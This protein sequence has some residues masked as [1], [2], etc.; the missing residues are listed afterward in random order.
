VN[1]S[2]ADSSLVDLYSESDAEFFSKAHGGQSFTPDEY[3][4]KE[5]WRVRPEQVEVDLPLPNKG[6]GFS[7]IPWSTLDAEEWFSVKNWI[8]EREIKD[9]TPDWK[10][11]L[12]QK[13]HQELMGKILQ[14]RGTCSVY[15]GTSK[16]NVQFLSQIFEG[17]E[18]ITENNSVAWIFLLDG[19]LMRVSPRS[20]I[21]FHEIN[22]S[23]TEIFILSRLNEGHLFWHPRKKMSFIPDLGAE[24]DSLSLPLLVREANQQYFERKIFHSQNDLERVHEVINLED[25]AVETQ[26]K[27]LNEIKDDNDR[28]LTIPTKLMMVF[29]N[30]T[31]VAKEVSFDLV[32][33]LGGESYFKKR[34]SSS[35]DVFSLFLR[36][37]LATE[38]IKDL[39]HQWYLVSPTGRTYS[40]ME[41]VHGPLQVLELLTKRIKTIELARE[42]WVKEFSVP[43]LKLISLPEKMAQTYGHTVWGQELEKRYQFLVDYTRRIETTNLGSIEKLLTKLEGQEKKGPIQLSEDLYS[44]SLNHYL[45]GL[46][47]RYDSKK[48]R[49]KEMN[50]LQYYVWILKNGK[51]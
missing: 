39:D 35:S 16:A 44:T 1:R 40:K 45:L 47:S 12:R 46:K 42:I 33:L 11:G 6:Q 37:Y 4:Q 5:S 3:H 51:I 32:Y 27:T 38:E 36:G 8:I 24:T 34:S 7:I 20:S 28:F 26:F 9:K 10:I 30:G 15:R 22:I 50:D 48:M 17:D 21:S 43:L 29:P 49:V 18:L 13:N 23:K 19:S 41:D 14:C 25:D 2:Y 31:L